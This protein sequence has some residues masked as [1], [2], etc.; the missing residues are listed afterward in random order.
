M[1]RPRADQPAAV[2]HRAGACA[3]KLP[4]PLMVIAALQVARAIT[5]EATLSFLGMGVPIAEPS[6]GLLIANGYQFCPT[7]T[8][9]ASFPVWR[10]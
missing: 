3:T 5:I 1:W 6:L 10:C 4:S 7:N 8:G 9:S 2:A